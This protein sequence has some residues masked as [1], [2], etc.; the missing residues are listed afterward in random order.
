MIH[1]CY[2]G[3]N[4]SNII[5]LW[6]GGDSTTRKWWLNP[7]KFV[8]VED[9][10][11]MQRRAK[12]F[13]YDLLVNRPTEFRAIIVLFMIA[14]QNLDEDQTL[15]TE[16][17]ERAV[18]L[19][20]QA[21]VSGQPPVK[22]VSTHLGIAKSSASELLKRAGMRLKIRTFEELFHVYVDDEDVNTWSPSEQQIKKQMA[23]ST[24]ECAASG[25]PHC[26]GTTRGRFALCLPCSQH[27][28][29]LR[30]QWVKPRTGEPLT[31]LL[32][33]ARRIDKQHRQDAINALYQSHT[34]YDDERIVKAA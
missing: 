11:T 28:G 1:R 23:K 24:R 30:E 17:Q 25:T 27:Y 3:V 32:E 14:Y 34:G 19:A 13:F 5:A 16:R 21:M 22:Y 15:L 12:V 9:I 26:K 29:A 2:R 31:W 18:I 20:R 33:E 7:Y 10:L 6:E 8:D 4:L